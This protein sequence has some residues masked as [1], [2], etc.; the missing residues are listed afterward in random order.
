MN[1]MKRIDEKLKMKY[2]CLVICLGWGAVLPGFSQRM[3]SLEEAIALARRQSVEAAVA[4][5]ELKAAYWEYHTYRAD[6]LPEVSFTGTLP[7]YNKIY[8][9]Y[10]QSDGSYTFVKNNNMGLDGA[11]SI[12]QNVWLTGGK[13]SLTTSL[14]YI[15]QL[16]DDRQQQFMNIPLSVT[17]TQP[18]FGVNSLKWQR[19]IAPV[20]YREAKAAFLSATEEVT[21]KTL[22]YFFQ[23]LLAKEQLYIARQNLQNTEKLYTIADSRRSIGQISQNDWLQLR[24]SVLKAKAAL[25]DNESNLKA[26]M[27]QLR[28]FLGL[29][30]REEIEPVLPE[31]VPYVDITYPDV[32]EK[33]LENHSFSQNIRRRQLE[34]D[35]A[36]AEAKGNLRKVDLYASLGLSGQDNAFRNVYH[37]SQWGNN[38]MVEV[39]VKIPILD[40]GKRRGKV[41]VAESERETV[42]AKIRQE[43]MDFNQDIF[44][45]VEHFNNQAAQLSI[46]NEA[47]SIARKR[48]NANVQAF[49]IGQ[50]SMLDLNDAQ[51]SKDEAR[52]TRISELYNY[53]YYLY[54]IRSLT[55]WDYERNRELSED[56]E[57]VIR[58][59]GQ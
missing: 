40:W 25:T 41:R 21:M 20:R 23:L 56:F 44:L 38:Q 16:D 6:L 13:L 33:A 2:L 24:L 12:D 30:E 18:L 17:F 22:T 43:Q 50:I 39:G 4:L 46:A 27:F 32:L 59:K 55:L 34:A 47:D 19:R 5:N 10:Q 9:R 14:S 1:E 48:Y 57:R 11:F 28:A 35:Y 49:M 7:A 3:L 26:K 29:G 52:Q 37:S 42:R 31:S 8:N 58:S 45:L 53:W 15:R 36:V 54:Q 51:S